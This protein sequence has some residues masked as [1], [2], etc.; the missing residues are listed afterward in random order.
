[1]LMLDDRPT[2]IHAEKHYVASGVLN[3]AKQNKL[4]VPYDISVAGYDDAPVAR[5]LWP[6]L[7]TVH[8][9]VEQLCKEATELLIR[10][11]KNEPAEFDPDT[12]HS[13]LVIRESTGPLVD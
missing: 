11:L 10:H 12:I 4:R 1:M 9:P 8:H 2:E 3:V 13:E 5:H 7:T 6:R